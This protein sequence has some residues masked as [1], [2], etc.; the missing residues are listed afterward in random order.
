M[1][2]LAN[3]KIKTRVLIGFGVLLG[4]LVLL[5]GV[6]VQKAQLIDESLTRINDVN[7]VKQRYAINFRGS[8]HDR[9]IALRDVVLVSEVAE[10]DMAI[11]DIRKLEAFYAEAAKGMDAIFAARTDILPEER[12][13]L[14]EIKKVEARTNPLVEKVVA[15]RRSG[16]N[17]EAHKILLG[18][19]R[20]NFTQWLAQINRFIDFQERDSSIIGAATRAEAKNFSTLML[21]VCGFCLLIGAGFAFWTIQSIL[22][23]RRLTDSMMRLANGDLTTDIPENRSQNE[24]GEIT[25]AVQVFKRNAI[26]AS[27][28]RDEQAAAEERSKQ[29]RVSEMQALAQR[30]EGDVQA[31]VDAVGR[32]SE[33]I[34]QSAEMLKRTAGN[35]EKRVDTVEMS[36]G[37]ATDS[38][39]AVAA[40]ADELSISIQEISKQ[41]TV[42]STKTRQ[43]SEQA[44]VTND[45]VDGLSMKAER[46][47]DVL[48]LI[49]NI[50]GQTNLLALNAT[51]EAARAGE[52]GKGFAVVASEVKSLAN[53]TARATEDIALRIA[54]IQ[55]ATGDAVRAIKEIAGTVAEV[56]HIAG[57]IAA[58]VE[59]QNSATSEIARSAQH[60]SQSVTTVSAAVSDVRSG[61]SQTGDA[62]Q[63]LLSASSELSGHADALR[64]QVDR[65]LASVRTGT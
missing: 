59:E 12:A 21:I 44:A 50:A 49:S 55:A 37:D 34:K 40:A 35:T 54:E 1:L 17:A 41:I 11:A 56:N 46:I 60:A 22:P 48:G 38:V 64:A 52:A 13:I 23:L 26:E 7:G 53:Q 36:A 6:G 15:L 25:S 24:V 63:H 8:V 33:Q 27:R 3:A 62:S 30:F 58:A 32:S 31:V 61:T 20:G 9:A 14:A 16:A 10:L 51:I 2:F 4:L 19:A 39:Q 47:G 18:E 42:S 65:F 29:A 28:L 45:I 57:S 5:T 43:A